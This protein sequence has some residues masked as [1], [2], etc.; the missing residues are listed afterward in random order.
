MP[1]RPP[2]GEPDGDRPAFPELTVGGRR[3]LSDY[4]LTR[5]KASWPLQVCMAVAFLCY[6]ALVFLVVSNKISFTSAGVVVLFSLASWFFLFWWYPVLETTT[7]AFAGDAGRQWIPR[8]LEIFA[9][10]CVVVVHALMLV[11]VAAT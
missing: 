9:I 8:A 1:P 11:I 10:V 4:A 5:L 3:R 6:G 2:P 7:E